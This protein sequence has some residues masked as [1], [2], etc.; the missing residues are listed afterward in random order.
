M[1]DLYALML[2]TGSAGDYM[3]RFGLDRIAAAKRFSEHQGFDAWWREQALDRQLAARPIRVPM[4]L[5]GGMYDEQDLYGAPA[6]FRALH[7]LDT[8]GKVSLLLGP[9]PHMGVNGDGT[10]LGAMTFPEDTAATARRDIIKPFLDARLKDAA[11][12]YDPPA[13]ISY[14]TGADRWRRSD[15][16]P[17]ASTPLYLRAGGR[18]SFDAPGAGEAKDD[19]VSDPAKPVPVIARPFYFSGRSDSWRTSLIADQRFASQRPDVLSFV[20]E[21]LAAPVHVFGQPQVELFAATSGT[22]S[23]FVVKLIDVAPAEMAEPELG[24]YQLPIGMEIFRGRFLKTLDTASPLTP[25]KPEA[26]RFALPVADHV[27]AKGHRIMVQVQSSWFPVYDRNPQTF[28]PSIFDAKPQDYRKA[29]QSVFHDAE[30]A[31]AVRLPIV[32]D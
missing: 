17:Q 9:W 19:Y 26:Y 32:R 23:D 6:V 30:R 7:P 13:V 4:L 21:P 29:T 8:T 14:A 31:S 5:V 3:R 11:A 27:F 22:D 15:A 28:V 24:G 10:R 18:L 1:V 12:P 16:M 25:G 2:E 20:T